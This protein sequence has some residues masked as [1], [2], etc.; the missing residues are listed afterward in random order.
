MLKEFTMSELIFRKGLWL[1][2]LIFNQ[3]FIV[4]SSLLYFKVYAT[5]LFEMI[6]IMCS[7]GGSLVILAALGFVFVNYKL[8]FDQV[9]LPKQQQ[10]EEE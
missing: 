6:G 1:L 8:I 7:L 9:I 2:F 10:K 5:T 4:V 3:V